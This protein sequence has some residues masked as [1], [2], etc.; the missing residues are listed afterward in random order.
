MGLTMLGFPGFMSPGAFSWRTL[1]FPFGSS[2]Q[3]QPTT[4]QSTMNLPKQ[5]HERLAQRTHTRTTAYLSLSESELAET[6]V[7]ESL[8]YQ[9]NVFSFSFLKRFKKEKL[10]YHVVLLY[11]SQWISDPLIGLSLTVSAELQCNL[12]VS[13]DMGSIV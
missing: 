5:Q 3:Q 7:A 9:I 11:G 6:T 10:Q 4:S 8:L 1:Y 2:I 13:E 12:K